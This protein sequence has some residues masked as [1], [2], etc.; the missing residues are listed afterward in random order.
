MAVLTVFEVGCG[1]HGLE[2]RAT[3]GAI[4]GT[5]FQLVLVASEFDMPAMRTVSL[6]SLSVLSVLSVALCAL[7]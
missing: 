5:H 6:F 1:P 2:T 3:G 4:R 7:C